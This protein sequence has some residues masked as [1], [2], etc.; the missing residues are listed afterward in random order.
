[1]AH[2]ARK[3][4]G[5]NFLHDKGVIDRIV[6]T[7]RLDAGQHWIE[8]GPGQGALTEPLINT[9]IQLDIIEFDRDLVAMLQNKYIDKPTLTIHSANALQ[10]D[11]SS[12]A[13]EGQ[14]LRIIGNLPYNISTPLLFH[15]L[16]FADDIETMYFML[17]KEVVDRMCAEPGSKKYGRLSVMLQYYCQATSLFEVYP[18]SFEPKPKVTSAIVRLIPHLQAPVKLNDLQQFERVVKQAFSM[19]RKTIRNSLKGFLNEGEISDL[20]IDPSC[21]AETLSLNDFA[22]LSDCYSTKTTKT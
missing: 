2:K 20:S 10:F 7:L 13:K 3:R 19:R 17:Q 4:F 22:R 16:D 1:M 8:I 5:Q 12:L 6:S 14:K 11:F 21:R 15:L 9:G 18:E